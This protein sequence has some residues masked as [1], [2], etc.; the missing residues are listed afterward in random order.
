MKNQKNVAM[1]LS[2][3]LCAV[4]M[5]SQVVVLSEC[6]GTFETEVPSDIQPTSDG[7]FIIVGM[8][9]PIDGIVSPTSHGGLDYYVAKLNSSGGM[10]WQHN[11]GGTHDEVARGIAELP[12]GEFVI[13]GESYS[14]DGDVQEHNGSTLFSDIWCIRIS[15][16]GDLLWSKSFGTDGNDAGA[17]ILYKNP[18]RLILGGT[19]KV[20]GSGVGSI[21]YNTDIWIAELDL[22]GNVLSESYYGDDYKQ[23]L[24]DMIR[25]PDDDLFIAGTTYTAGEN[26]GDGSAML[27]K[28]DGNGDEDWSIS[29]DSEGFNGIGKSA[30]ICQDADENIIM[31]FQ[32]SL[33]ND[34]VNCNPHGSFHFVSVS[35]NGELLI[36]KCFGGGGID[37]SI[38]AC[39]TGDGRIWIL[40][41][42]TSDDGDVSEL[43]FED[44][45]GNAWLASLDEDM[46]ITW[47][48]TLGGS[49]VD[50][51]VDM[52]VQNGSII[53]VLG[54]TNSDDG[55][56]EGLHNEY[57]DY[58]DN[59]VVKV[60][61][62][63]TS[64]VEKNDIQIGIYPN[65]A[66]ESIRVEVPITQ[67]NY[68]FRIFDQTGSLAQEG[69]INT[70]SHEIMLDGISSGIYQLMLS[71][72]HGRM[73]GSGRLVK[74]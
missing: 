66:S 11:Y 37:Q 58:Q 12:T 40:G 20:E 19:K 24:F 42:T 65:P 9:Q 73:R 63:Q 54:Y 3:L 60:D 57:G 36:Q 35:E 70:T 4:V 26:E 15:P 43:P 61:T 74:S 38:A 71:D 68:Y 62:E 18:N 56:V 72:T 7:G 5:N 53:F 39:M 21:P 23:E 28:I 44:N 6:V 22:N 30:K 1:M 32:T 55:I 48:T 13:I 51:A 27:T 17:D 59:W 2:L 69:W 52:C 10:D 49:K 33:L 67:E 34:E 64:V 16:T 25:T 45:G 14:N 47:K 8:C 50:G 41:T 29:F 31:G 46:N